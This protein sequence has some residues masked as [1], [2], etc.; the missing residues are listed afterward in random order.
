MGHSGRLVLQ[1][2]KTPRIERLCAPVGLRE[3]VL[4]ALDLGALRLCH[5]F[6]AGQRR[7][8]LVT[9][10]RGEQSAQVVT[11]AAALAERTEEGVKLCRERLQRPRGRR[12]RLTGRHR[13]V[14]PML[15]LYASLPNL[16][17]HRYTR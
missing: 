17:N 5:R 3:K 16:T 14:P 8:R 9:I 10:A 7:E 15:S 11:K 4:Q 6:R 13:Q 1:Q 2:N 12:T